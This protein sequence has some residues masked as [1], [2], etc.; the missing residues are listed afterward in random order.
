MMRYSLRTLLILVSLCCVYAAWVGYLRNRAEYHRRESARIVNEL[1]IQTDME[2]KEIDTLVLNI[3][4][5]SRGRVDSL[6]F[7]VQPL[8]KP[9]E[10]FDDNTTMARYR[11]AVNHQILAATCDKALWQPWRIVNARFS[12]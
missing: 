9:V 7:G 2:V 1:S 5:R 6:R 8:G 11:K 3:A 4:A 10:Y 12:P